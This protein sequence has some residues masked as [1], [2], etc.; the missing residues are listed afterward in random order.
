MLGKHFPGYTLTDGWADW[1]CPRCSHGDRDWTTAAGIVTTARVRWA[2]RD[3][4]PYKTA[5]TDGIFPALLQQG[6]EVILPPVTKLLKACVTLGYIPQQWR[7]TRVVFIP[8][9]GKIDYDQAGVYKLI[10]LTS[11][12]LKILERLIDRHVRDGPLRI[13]PL[14]TAVRLP[15]GQIH[16]NGI[17]QAGT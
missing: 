4:E 16:R 12:L 1:S 9:P 13:R 2:I 6:L 15:G 17:A 10:S 11:F 3:L 5:G 14:H 7:I 8:K